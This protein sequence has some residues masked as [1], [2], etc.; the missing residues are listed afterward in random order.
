MFKNWYSNFY[1]QLTKINNNSNNANGNGGNHGGG[2]G[3]SG[4]FTA[5]N[6]INS[7][8]NSNTNS[9]SSISS[10]STASTGSTPPIDSAD[11]PRRAPPPTVDPP[12]TVP[13][14][15]T[16]DYVQ[17]LDNKSP[18]NSVRTAKTR[19]SFNGSSALSQHHHSNHQNQSSSAGLG[20]GLGLGAGHN[21]S[22]NSFSIKHNPNSPKQ[23]VSTS[24][25]KMSGNLPPKVKNTETTAT[26]TSPA[27][28]NI[29]TARPMGPSPASKSGN[30]VPSGR[31]SVPAEN[32]VTVSKPA[33]AANTT[34][35]PNNNVAGCA[36][37][38][39][40]AGGGGPRSEHAAT[41]I[42]F[43]NLF[44]NTFQSLVHYGDNIGARIV[45][46]LINESV[47]ENQSLMSQEYDIYQVSV[48]CTWWWKLF[49]L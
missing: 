33:T 46:C 14:I 35:L 22:S 41:N 19:A 42:D 8:A 44:N 4:G 21:K 26:T 39:T 25:N 43:S 11:T 30:K 29:P 23:V 13:F 34:T 10:I 49:D 27:R 45:K 38:S 2:G 17:L 15:S 40:A 16:A 12:F 18:P 48:G 3:S 7:S 31:T 24:L 37:N 32:V 20:H 28:S 9:A 6:S 36:V 1:N 47:Y 5:A